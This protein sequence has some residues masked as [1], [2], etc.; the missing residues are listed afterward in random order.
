MTN[1][2]LTLLFYYLFPCAYWKPGHI[3]HIRHFISIWSDW[4]GCWCEGLWWRLV[5][6]TRKWRS[7]A[8][9]AAAQQWSF[10]LALLGSSH[11]FYSG[12]G[13]NGL[14]FL[15]CSICVTANRGKMHITRQCLIWKKKMLIPICG[16]GFSESLFFLCRSTEVTWFIN[17]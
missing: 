2:D 4:S 9:A 1:L 16:F 14:P 5:S 3:D 12:R 11:I 7:D 8:A 6:H 13:T 15:F 10:W 17:V